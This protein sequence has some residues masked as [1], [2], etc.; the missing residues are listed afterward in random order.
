M[1][2]EIRQKSRA[3]RSVQQTAT[4]YGGTF[5]HLRYGGYS[6]PEQVHGRSM[7]HC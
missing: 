5:G 4:D 7:A 3:V 2:K 1:T 6:Q